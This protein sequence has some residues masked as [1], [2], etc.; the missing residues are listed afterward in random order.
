MSSLDYR[1]SEIRE[2]LAEAKALRDEAARSSGSGG[3]GGLD[4]RVTRLEGQFDRIVD[5]IDRQGERLAD[6]EGEL[7]GIRERLS[8][9]PTK[10]EIWKIAAGLIAATAGLITFGEK[11]QALVG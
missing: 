2:S 9:M 4:Q 3:G 11:L 7:K 6:V 5:K 1:F 10:L 8:H